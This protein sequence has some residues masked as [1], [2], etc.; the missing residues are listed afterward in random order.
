[1]I[2]VIFLIDGEDS[3]LLVHFHNQAIIIGKACQLAEFRR[4]LQSFKAFSTHIGAVLGIDATFLRTAATAA[5]DQVRHEF[6]ANFRQGD[7][8]TNHVHGIHLLRDNNQGLV[9]HMDIQ[10][11][12]VFQL[13]H[14][15]M[16]RTDAEL[17][18]IVDHFKFHIL[19]SFLLID[20]GLLFHQGGPLP[21]GIIHFLSRRLFIVFTPEF[22]L[23]F[24]DQL[25]LLILFLSDSHSEQIHLNSIPMFIRVIVRYD[26]F[27]VAAA[28]LARH[29][30]R[31]VCPEDVK[32][33]VQ[34]A[35]EATVVVGDHDEPLCLA[36]NIVKPCVIPHGKLHRIVIFRF[37]I[38][39]I[40][41]KDGALSVVLIY[42][43]FKVPI[44]NYHLRQPL[45]TLPNQVKE[46]ADVAGTS[47]KCCCVAI[48]TVANQL[49]I[50]RRSDHI[51][52]LGSLQ[53]DGLDLLEFRGRKIPFCQFQ[54]FF[55]ILISEAFHQ[56]E[57]QQYRKFIA[58]IQWQEGQFLQQKEWPFFDA[59]HEVRQ[60]A[61]EVV[62]DLQH[63]FD[64]RSG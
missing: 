20:F 63:S 6:I 24:A 21:G 48:E 61:V 41:V 58:G 42:Q 5:L 51:A 19:S 26:E 4:N 45:R 39:R 47:T 57:L 17:L 27:S 56:E 28:N 25:V 29:A 11:F 49:K 12:R 10:K 53:Q 34:S 8:H 54:I 15:Q 9:L 33:F 40:A 3:I 30:V 60:V 59:V 32:V 62:V 35:D 43:R 14:S 22:N 13:T 2:I 52:K 7:Q 55:Q 37:V 23:R 44:L 50:V 16:S 18:G 1:M 31:T 46:A 36:K 64:D 38:R